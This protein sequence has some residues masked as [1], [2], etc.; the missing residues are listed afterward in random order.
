MEMDPREWGRIAQAV[1]VLWI[2]LRAPALIPVESTAELVGGVMGILLGA[3]LF[4]GLPRAL[5]VYIGNRGDD[6][7]LTTS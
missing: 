7:D 2:L 3:I 5:I 1:L 4:V 6:G